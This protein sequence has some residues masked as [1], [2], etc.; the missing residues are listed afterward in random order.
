MIFKNARNN[1]SFVQEKVRRKD[2]RF[3]NAILD[4]NLKWLMYLILYCNFECEI[5]NVSK[6]FDLFPSKICKI[7]FLLYNFPYIYICY[8]R[9]PLILCILSLYCI[10]SH[11][12][13]M[14]FLYVIV[15]FIICIQCASYRLFISIC[16]E[17]F[18]WL[19]NK[20]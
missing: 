2:Y 4:P 17:R 11:L 14:F 18:H 7:S 3:I 1:V 19:I 8:Y 5:L 10:N 13:W 12:Y 6:H 20:N 15:K 9:I 16:C